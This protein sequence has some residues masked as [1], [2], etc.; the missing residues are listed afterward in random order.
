MLRT[1]KV[2]TLNLNNFRTDDRRTSGFLLSDSPVQCLLKSRNSDHGMLTPIFYDF[3]KGGTGKK[4]PNRGGLHLNFG[5][6]GERVL[7]ES[8]RGR[9]K[10][11]NRGCGIGIPAY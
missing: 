2:E 7:L 11:S 3:S 8:G 4:V 6:F 10:F 5:P 1:S 9:T